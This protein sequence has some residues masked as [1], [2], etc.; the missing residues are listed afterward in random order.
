MHIIVESTRLANNALTS[1]AITGSR[2]A[3]VKLA[4]A[5]N[6]PAACDP[7]PHAPGLLITGRT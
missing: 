4:W 3:S 2:C 5:K 6:V 7:H 1:L